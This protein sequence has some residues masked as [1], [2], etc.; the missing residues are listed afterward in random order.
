MALMRS[1]ASTFNYVMH[2]DHDLKSDFS[3]YL[4]PFN[5]GSVELRLGVLGGKVSYL[6]RAGSHQK[7]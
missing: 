2:H 4:F 3:F 5:C 1:K 6:F 7:A